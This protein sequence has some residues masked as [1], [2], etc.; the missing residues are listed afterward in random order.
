MTTQ[1]ILSMNDGTGLRVLRAEAQEEEP[2]NW[3]LFD[4]YQHIRI[5]T[6]SASIK[7]IVRILNDFSFESVECIFGAEHIL[8]RLS[9]ILN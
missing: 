6:Y 7:T 3:N 5:L 8:N 2:F 9:D 4:G 1:Q